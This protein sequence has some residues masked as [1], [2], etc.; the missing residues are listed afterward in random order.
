[1]TI[2]KSTCNQ[3]TLC[4][5]LWVKFSVM[6]GPTRIKQSS[7]PGAASKTS[8][9]A[10]KTEE[11]LP[12]PS[13][14]TE[15][16]TQSLASK[17]RQKLDGGGSVP[18]IEDWSP[19]HWTDVLD[20][21]RQ[22]RRRRDAPVDNMGAESFLKDVADPKVARLHV[23]VS[24]MLSSQ[25][26]DEVNHAA[27]TRLKA[28]GLTVQSLLEM[29]EQTLAEMIKPVGFWRKKAVYLQ[30]MA[31]ILQ[32]EYEADI[33]STVEQLC[34]L[35]GVGPK[36]AHL[37]TTIAWGNVTGIGVD[38]HVHRISNRLGWVQRPTS[39]PEATRKALE[40]WLPRQHWAEINL[41]LVGFGQQICMPVAPHCGDCLNF[42][43][44]P[45]A[46]KGSPKKS[47]SKQG[48]RAAAKKAKR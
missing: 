27:M 35:P 22:M 24:L 13:D 6:P 16:K 5:S 12:T 23:L 46:T 26:R 7:D 41:L 30:K 19:P 48:T 14:Q 4:C 45:A 33:P 44:C 1:L 18:D 38:T 40:A 47:A 20:N 17:L 8:E 25:T 21:I 43:L 31:R 39:T 2:K 29:K 36:M 42:S 37:C 3:R 34:R 9:K 10:V 28:D 11:E 15:G 32:D